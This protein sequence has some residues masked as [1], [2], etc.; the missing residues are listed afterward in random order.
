MSLTE[1]AR[2]VL[3]LP[4]ICFINKDG[5]YI[6]VNHFKRKDYSDDILRFQLINLQELK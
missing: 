1:I 6:S 3:L 5:L 4:Q 2:F